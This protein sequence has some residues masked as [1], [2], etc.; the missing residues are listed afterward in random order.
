MSTGKLAVGGGRV[1]A[2]RPEAM[3]LEID[4]DPHA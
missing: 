3:R 4:R 2:A 1:I